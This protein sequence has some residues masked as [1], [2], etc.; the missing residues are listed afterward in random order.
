MFSEWSNKTWLRFKAIWKRRQ[1]DRDLNDEAAFHLSMREEKNRLAGIDAEEARY[2]AQRQFGNATG[3]KERSREMWT[4]ASLEGFL[5][6]VRLALRMLLKNPGFTAVAVLTL[7]LGVGANTAI[8]SVINGVLLTP[9]PYKDPQRI[10]VMKRNDSLPNVSDI[11]RQTRSFSQSGGINIDNMDYTSG[12][13]PM[14]VRAGRVNAGF[15][16]TL[17]VPPMLGRIISQEEDV[18]GGPRFVVLS[19]PFW[20][21]FLSSDPQVLGKT[22]SLSGNDYT[23][24]GVM[25]ANFVPP[26]EHADVFVSLWVAYPD[27][28]SERDVHF[29]HTYWRLNAGVTLSQAQAE[30]S[31][32]DHRLAE[33][34]P[35]SET[36]RRTV[37]LPLQ[38]SVTGS[39]RPAL[40]VLFGAVGFVLLI[41]CANFAGLLMA[42]AVARRQEIGIRTALG[43][44]KSRL[45]RQALTESVLLAIVGGGAGLLLARLGISLLLS[46]KPAA[47]DRFSGIHLDAHVLFFVFGISLLTGIVFGI[48]P[49]WSVTNVDIAESLKEGARGSTSGQSGNF[50]RKLLVTA[51]FALALVLLVGAG[52][53]IKGFSRLRSVSPGFNPQ[54]VMTMHLQLPETRYAK[55]PRQ[56]QF[57]VQALER[58]SA[59]PGV[60]AAMVMDR[61]LST[62]DV[63]YRVIV[64][65]D[66]PVA[67]GAEPRAQTN[68]VMGDYF[69]VMQIPI[70]A[71]REFT[72]LDREGQPLVAIVNEEFVKERLPHRNPIGARIDWARA[73]DPPRWMTIVGVVADVKDSSLDAPADPAVYT[74]FPQSEQVWRRWMTLVLR[75]TGPVPGLVDEVKKQVWSVDSQIPIT[76]I[77]SME[78]LMAVSLAQQRFNMLLLA[79]FAVLALILAAVGIYG[80]MAYSVSQRTHEIGVRLAIGA[81]RGDVLR[82]VLRDGARL[83]LLG[84][85]IGIIAALALTRLM[86]SLLFEVTPT[87]PATFAAVAIVLAVT[88]FAACYIPAR[89]ATRVDPMVALRYD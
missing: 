56:T 47:L 71:G 49:A 34:Y 55:I 68:S 45:I 10:V 15:L 29:M 16:E 5:Q 72:P 21:N 9:L 46:L 88:A 26:R 87:D 63:N 75:T 2:A 61:P 32:M 89:R 6:D 67:V 35:D 59:L 60:Q 12:T 43:A 22:I 81:Q 42:R 65:G 53:L 40:L 4:F 20:Q 84:I 85:A 54:N 57:R 44:G 7:A 39:V 13:E 18:K 41:A 83:T 74:P 82:L 17:G 52:L 78:D 62:N 37:F 8:F 50:L 31:A 69:H 66:P 79:L 77:L 23:V 3:L 58:L 28:A 38:E 76:D 30:I 51:E 36:D 86:V 24:I 11:L 73:P 70:R 48:A 27:G 80:L 25:P 1:L 19:Y 14:Q 33:L 64:D